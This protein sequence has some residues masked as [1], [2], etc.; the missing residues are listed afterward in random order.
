MNK[1]L[2]LFNHL[3]EIDYL[4]FYQSEMKIRTELNYPP[5]NRLAELELKHVNE[6]Q[7]EK[8]TNHLVDQLY[9]Y[10]K[11]NNLPITILG[12]AKPPVSKIKSVHSRKI[13]LKAENFSTIIQLCKQINKKKHT[14]SIYFTPNPLS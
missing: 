7:L 11:N 10:I 5:A 9:A 3:N 8:D 13:Y 4:K 1:V 14:S 12:P 6:K 2:L